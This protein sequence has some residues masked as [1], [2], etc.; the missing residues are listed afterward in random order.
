MI[1]IKIKTDRD[2]W[3]VRTSSFART[4]LSQGIA[5]GTRCDYC[6]Q[7]RQAAPLKPEDFCVINTP[8]REWR[9]SAGTACS[10]TAMDDG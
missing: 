5:T 9:E 6:S 2:G 3:A 8:G 4:I 7:M 1:Y 10:Q